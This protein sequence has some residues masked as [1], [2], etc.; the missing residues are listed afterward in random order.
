MKNR[1]LG[2]IYLNKARE[3]KKK[4]ECTVKEINE[5]KFVN[6]PSKRDEMK[7]KAR[8]LFEMYVDLKS[9]GE[10]LTGEKLNG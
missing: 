6:K 2:E 8:I 5:G 3:M 7:S 4:Y 10:K 1:E 9:V